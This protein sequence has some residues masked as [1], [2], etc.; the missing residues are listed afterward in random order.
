MQFTSFA[1]AA[2]LVSVSSAQAVSQITDGQIQ[3]STST[4]L[5]KSTVQ[6]VSQITDGQIQATTS[7]PTVAEANGA[8]K[9]AGSF[10]AAGFAAAALLL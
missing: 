9:V 5:A 3:A 8:A 10:A 1:L 7:T 6:A 4:T 2:V